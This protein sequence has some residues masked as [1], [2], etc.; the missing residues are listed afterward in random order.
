MTMAVAGL[1][2]AFG[3]L[4]DEP[5]AFGVVGFA[6]GRPGF[7]DGIVTLVHRHRG[8]LAQL[9]LSGSSLPT[10]FP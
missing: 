3:N 5:L 4:A 8:Y 10:A 7:S 9:R 2:V 6:L 1:A